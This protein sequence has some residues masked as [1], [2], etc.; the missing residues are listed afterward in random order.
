MDILKKAPGFDKDHWPEFANQ[1]WSAT[2]EEYYG[3]HPE[4]ASRPSQPPK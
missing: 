2:V 3:A 4:T 1:H